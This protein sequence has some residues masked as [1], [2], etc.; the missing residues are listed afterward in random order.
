LYRK[1]SVL[2]AENV[3][4]TKDPDNDRDFFGIRLKSPRG[5]VDI[6]EKTVFSLSFIRTRF[7]KVIKN[8]KGL[9]RSLYGR[10]LDTVWPKAIVLNFTAV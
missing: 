5:D 10:R 3:G 9:L 7:R 2:S 1:R 6:E 8:M 4:S